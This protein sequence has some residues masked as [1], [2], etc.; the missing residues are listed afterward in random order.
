M[1]P[2]E[3][4]E[5]TKEDLVLPVT[6]IHSIPTKELLSWLVPRNGHSECPLPLLLPS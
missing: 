5:R 3:E 1:D 4:K 6:S 2:E